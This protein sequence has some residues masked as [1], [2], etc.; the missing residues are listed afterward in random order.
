MKKQIIYCVFIIVCLSLSGCAA[1]NVDSNIYSAE[2]VQQPM[3][4]YLGTVLSVNNVQIKNQNQPSGV[5]T[6]AGGV[7]GAIIGSAMGHGPDRDVATVFG[8]LLGAGVGTVAEQ[9][10]STIPGLEIEVD[11]DDGKKVLIVQ[12]KDQLFTVGERVRVVEDADGHMRVRS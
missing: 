1:P 2:Q 9:N 12:G 11:L 10:G 5:G 6:V 7:A 4:V 8:A 3:R